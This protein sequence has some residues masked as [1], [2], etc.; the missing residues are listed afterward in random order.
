M[1]MVSEYQRVATVNPLARLSLSDSFTHPFLSALT[2]IC[3]QGDGQ[4]LYNDTERNFQR[5]T[6]ASETMTGQMRRPTLVSKPDKVTS[7]GRYT[8][9]T[10]EG[11][12]PDMQAVVA[13]RGLYSMAVPEHLC[14]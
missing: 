7:Q 11:G 1:M 6:E 8:S 9:S 4:S 3:E 14:K 5:E 2:S 12:R 10:R 13:G